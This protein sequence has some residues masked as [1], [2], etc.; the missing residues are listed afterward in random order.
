MIFAA[1]LLPFSLLTGCDNDPEYDLSQ[2]PVAEKAPKSQQENPV[3][4]KDDDGLPPIE[5]V[6]DIEDNYC[7]PPYKQKKVF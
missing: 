3:P 7:V 2:I 1:S 6:E 5:T 4:P